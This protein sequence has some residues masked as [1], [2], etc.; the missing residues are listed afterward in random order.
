MMLKCLNRYDADVKEPVPYGPHTSSTPPNLERGSL[1]QIKLGADKFAN[2][3]CNFS[4]HHHDK[5]EPVPIL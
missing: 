5:Y 1:H 2:L 3:M 4:A